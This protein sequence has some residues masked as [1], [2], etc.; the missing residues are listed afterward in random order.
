LTRSTDN[1]ADIKTAIFPNGNMD[2]YERTAE[3]AIREEAAVH[4]GSA[5]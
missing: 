2:L 3:S 4:I 1:R 5:R